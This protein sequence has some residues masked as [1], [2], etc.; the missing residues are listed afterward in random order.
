MKIFNWA[1]DIFKNLN[2]SDSLSS[3]LNLAINI[4]ILVVVAYFIRLSFK[5]YS[6][7]FL[8]IVAARTKST[9]VISWLPIKQL[10]I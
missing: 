8:A 9:F 5:N 7:F 3:Y 2:C 4:I 10:N 6:L 1:Y